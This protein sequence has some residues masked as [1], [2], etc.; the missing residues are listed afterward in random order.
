MKFTP[1]YVQKFQVGGTMPQDTAPVEEQMPVEQ[2][3]PAE[4]PQQDPIQMLAQAAVQALQQQSCEMAFQVCQGFV[5]LLQQAQQGAPA[6]E[7]QGTPVFKKG[8]CLKKRVKK[9]KKC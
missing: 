6:P 2:A 1:N 3:A 4:E 5:Q 8:G 7:D 9:N